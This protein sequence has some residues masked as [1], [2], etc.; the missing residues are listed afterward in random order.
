[1][2]PQNLEEK[3]IWY[4]I[5]GTYVLYLLGL[6]HMLAPF[7]GWGLGFYVCIKLW[8]QTDETPEE[9]K[10]SIPFG[11][12]VWLIFALA[13][14]VIT[15]INHLDFDMGLVRIIK[16]TINFWAKG[17][18]LFAL[19]VLI[20]S[21]LK[22]RPQLLYRASSILGLQ[23]LIL[24]PIS[25]LAGQ[26]RLNQILYTSPLYKVGAAGQ[27]PYS[28]YLYGMQPDTDQVRLFLFAPW[29][30][31]LALVACVYFFL[32]WKDPNKKWRWI[33]MISYA[34]VVFAT[35]SRLGILVMIAIPP[36]I[37]CLS[38]FLINPTLQ[39]TTGAASIL[40]GFF[41][42]QLYT[43]LRDLKDSLDGQRSNSSAVRGMLAR[44]A[45]D[46]WQQH[47]PI[48]GHGLADERGPYLV[49]YK[50]IGSHHTWYGILFIHGLAGFIA[51]AT[52]VT[53]SLIELLIK[54]QKS[55][56][57][58]VGLSVLLVLL[59]FSIGENLDALIYL[60]WPGMIIIGIAFKERM[61]TM[62][63]ENFE[64]DR[65]EMVF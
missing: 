54:A 15:I 46:R 42:Q 48:W 33:G 18:G 65:K 45:R 7:L 41:G 50:P 2:K 9:D 63:S 29:A 10:I 17:W 38:N 16:T 53:L 57:A 61:S 64:E 28:V 56:V 3:I 37:W 20:G 6:Q 19:F 25:M 43:G 32:S 31:G 58:E 24:T 39:I 4:Y 12:W 8:N 36:A 11:A 62:Y 51:F 55:Q 30:P 21:C 40:A 1:M 49:A 5:T 52:T 26:L 22:I 35:A 27:V 60:F 23:S 59:T 34:V 14:E 44:M 13:M 47:A